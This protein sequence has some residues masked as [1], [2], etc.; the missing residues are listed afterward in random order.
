MTIRGNSRDWRLAAALVF[1]SV[2]LCAACGSKLVRG[3]SPAVRMNEMSHQDGNINLQLSMRNLNDVALD[4]TGISLVLKV[5]ESE[6]VS[7]AGALD[8][9]ISARGTETWSVDVE[10]S[11]ASRK[12]L[13]SLQ[14]GEVKSLPYSMEGSI[15]T[16]DSGSL[17][18]EFEGHIYPLPGR[19][20]YFR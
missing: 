6:L 9:N 1:C 17:K 11:E 16:R 20:G 14:N 12:L 10:E 3:V 19:P 7:Y 18:F 5:E 8:T 13:E 15:S 2:L 4:I